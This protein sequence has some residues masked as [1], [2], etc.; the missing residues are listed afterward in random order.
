MLQDPVQTQ[1]AAARAESF[2]MGYRGVWRKKEG[3]EHVG[4]GRQEG[5]QERWQA[6]ICGENR[7]DAK[8]VERNK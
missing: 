3:T 1:E 8:K 2:S 5:R 7:L 6:K 4:A